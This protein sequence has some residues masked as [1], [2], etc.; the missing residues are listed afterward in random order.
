MTERRGVRWVL[1]YLARGIKDQ[2]LYTYTMKMWA[3]WGETFL[4]NEENYQYSSIN[5]LIINYYIKKRSSE[6]FE[7][8]LYSQK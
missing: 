7:Y 1:L 6:R 3:N 2:T 5:E 8:K 4:N